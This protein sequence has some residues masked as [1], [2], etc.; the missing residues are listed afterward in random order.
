M[1]VEYFELAAR[2]GLGQ[3]PR[4]PRL[5]E[6]IANHA[7]AQ[8]LLALPGTVTQMAQKL[9]RPEEEIAAMMRTLF[10]KGLVFSSARNRS[11][12]LPHVP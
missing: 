10:V 12:N 11:P 7:E 1:D 9:R 2:I 3:S 8:L 6:I 5:F 4:I